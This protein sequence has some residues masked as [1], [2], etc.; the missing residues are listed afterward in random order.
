MASD[1]AAGPELEAA[2]IG[3]GATKLQ[4]SG[5]ALYRLGKMSTLAGK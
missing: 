1:Y 4:G 5:A 3:A 2:A